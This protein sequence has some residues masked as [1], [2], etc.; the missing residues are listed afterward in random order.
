MLF[1]KGYSTGWCTFGQSGERER[2][3]SG[4]R[5]RDFFEGSGDVREGLE[6][7]VVVDL[8][9]EMVFVGGNCELSCLAE[10]LSVIIGLL[11]HQFLLLFD[12]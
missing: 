12:A 11:V 5:G 6:F 8:L 3:W 9:Q 10:G 4:L 7:I 2:R 1:G